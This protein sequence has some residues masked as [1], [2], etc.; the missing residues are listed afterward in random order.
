M[1]KNIPFGISAIAYFYIF[2]AVVLIYSALFSNI[3]AE[4]IGISIRFGLPFIPEMVMRIA[5]AIVSFVLAYGLLNLKK[6]GFWGMII[7]SVYFLFVSIY[8]SNIYYKQPFYGN[9]V[10][11]AIVLGYLI[12]N[13]KTFLG[14]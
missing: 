11:S 10:W 12:S 4:E 5:V 14:K 2:G 1:K 13:R 6:W 3:A 7:Y 8:Y 9:T